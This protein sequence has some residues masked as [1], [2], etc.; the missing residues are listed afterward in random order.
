[1]KPIQSILD[2]ELKI[3]YHSRSLS[4]ASVQDCFIKKS[5][6][7]LVLIAINYL[8]FELIA[9]GFF[10]LQF[11][12][13]DA[14]EMQLERIQTIQRI[15]EQLVGNQ[16]ADESL[17]VRVKEVLHPY[18]G[19]AVDGKVAIKDC[20]RNE[21]SSPYD[22]YARI[23]ASNDSP[24]PKRSPDSL[25]VALL[26][27][28]VAVG[29]VTGIK[30]N[31]I[32]TKL[33]QLPEYRGRNV[34]LHVL[35]AGGYRQPQP[36]MLL[37]MYYAMGAEYDLIISL[38]G[39]NDVT[40]GP[41]EYKWNKTHP[42]YPRSWV[43]RVA[44][45]VSPELVI[46]QARKLDLQDTHRSRARLL[47]NPWC[48]N[49]PMWNLIWRILHSR[50]LSEESALSTQM[51]SVSSSDDKPRD[52][53]YE[54]LGPDYKFE[55]W[56]GVIEY[57]A[58]LWARSNHLAD[59]VAKA[60]GAK[61][62]HFVQPNQYVDGSKPSMSEQERAIALVTPEQGGYGIW[63]RQG[64]KF[65]QKHQSWLRDQG[66][67]TTDLSQIYK[68]ETGQIYIDNCCHMNAR[69]YS[70]I[71]DAMVETIHQSNLRN[72]KGQE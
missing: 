16:D 57:A 33:A 45:R 62:F 72:L 65:V 47:T 5:L 54:E 50:F 63:Y 37:N 41:I 14:H 12:E 25:N 68:E 69:G 2:F 4:S 59:G 51:N 52:F 31:Y 18:A 35:A 7:Y 28:S 67:N 55:S 43:A 15:D 56:D 61:F 58:Q 71:V 24:L 3:D 34:N 38:D 48:R 9:Y 20:E 13:Y 70:M 22:C 44:N 19:Y 64:Y 27:G 29:T 36:L 42:I 39:F 23:R 21:N 60:H 11:G 10:R 8:V 49:S 66:V 26:G 40:I 30:K 17:S 46:L 1:M 53:R 6:F 32:Q